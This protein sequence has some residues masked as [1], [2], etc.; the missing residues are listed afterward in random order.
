MSLRKCIICNEKKDLSEFW[1]DKR[2]TD[3]YLRW[4]NDCHRAGRQYEISRTEYMR[5]YQKKRR[6][7][8][9][10]RLSANIGTAIWTSLKKEKKGQKWEPLVGYTLEDLKKHLEKQFIAPMCWEN[11]GKWHIDHKI[12][13]SAFNFLKPEH[14]DF[15]RCWAL[16]NLRPLWGTDNLKKHNKLNKPFQPNLNL[17]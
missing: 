16:K 12:P 5:V 13:K 7:D 8:P 2:C 3:G 17:D 10:Y 9:Q 6:Q 15:K 1:E 4:C 11:Y 14:R